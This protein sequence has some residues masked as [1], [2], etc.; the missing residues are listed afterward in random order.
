[1]KFPEGGGGDTIVRRRNLLGSYSR[2]MP[3]V[4][5]LGLR[6]RTSCEV[7]AKFCALPPASCSPLKS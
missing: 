7:T 5:D 3:R 6:V 2:P 1:M 4:Q